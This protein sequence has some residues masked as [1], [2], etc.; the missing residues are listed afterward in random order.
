MK[1]FNI[2]RVNS[3]YKTSIIKTFLSHGESIEYLANLI[4]KEYKKED[5]SY[6]IYYTSKDEITIHYVG[7]LSKGLEVKYFIIEYEDD[8]QC[9]CGYYEPLSEEEIYLNKKL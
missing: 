3:D 7:Y 9:V 4:D 2:V 5:N 1:K 6:K 8:T